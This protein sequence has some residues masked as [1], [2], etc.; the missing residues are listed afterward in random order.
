MIYIFALAV[1]AVILAADIITGRTAQRPPAPFD[2]E[3][4]NARK[5]PGQTAGGDAHRQRRNPYRYRPTRP[6][7]YPGQRRRPSNPVAHSVRSPRL[8]TPFN[9]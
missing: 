1:F 8:F 2:P 5:S 9:L 7:G 4:G 3:T 6:T